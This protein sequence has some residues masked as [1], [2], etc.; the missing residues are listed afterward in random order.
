VLQAC[1]DTIKNQCKAD[2]AQPGGGR[3]TA[4][5]CLTE[6]LR[7]NKLEDAECRSW[8]EAREACK[9]DVMKQTACT[10]GFRRCLGK[11]GYEQY[12][13]NIAGKAPE[14]DPVLSAA[15]TKT[16]YYRSVLRFRIMRERRSERERKLTA[17]PPA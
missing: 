1:S 6:A 3:K 5:K 7:A 15:C 10:L 8:V 13:D 16:P 4:V 17:V 9:L 14:G 12:L 2:A 11:L